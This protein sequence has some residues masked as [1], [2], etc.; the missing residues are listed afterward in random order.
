[1]TFEIKPLEGYGK[2]ETGD[3]KPETRDGKTFKR[4]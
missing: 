1:M 4:L 3:W 2:M